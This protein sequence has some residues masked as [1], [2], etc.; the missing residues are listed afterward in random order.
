MGT[1]QSGSAAILHYKGNCSN[2]FGG[3]KVLNP[4]QKVSYGNITCGVVGGGIT[5]CLDS[6][7][8]THGFVLDPAGSWAF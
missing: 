3:N 8:G 7:N 4:G 2:Q 5:A 6:S 1:A